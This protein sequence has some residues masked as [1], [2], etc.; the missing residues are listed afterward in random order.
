MPPLHPCFHREINLVDARKDPPEHGK[1]ATATLSSLWKDFPHS[2]ESEGSHKAARQASSLSRLPREL[3]DDGQLERT[4][5][6]GAWQD[7]WRLTTEKCRSRFRISCPK[8]PRTI[9]HHPAGLA[10]KCSKVGPDLTSTILINK[11]PQVQ[12]SVQ[13][14]RGGVTGA[15]IP[16]PAVRSNFQEKQVYTLTKLFIGFHK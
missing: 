10:S 14:K 4:Q 1:S 5:A 6:D 9:D 2:G 16:V 3:F 12:F 7:S 8:A 13:P 15:P 11:H